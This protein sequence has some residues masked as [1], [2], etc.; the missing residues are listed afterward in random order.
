MSSFSRLTMSSPHTSPLLPRSVESFERKLEDAQKALNIDPR[1]YVPVLYL[2]ETSHFRELL[3][4]VPTV[5]LVGEHSIRYVLEFTLLQHVY[6]K[7]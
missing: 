7:L 4:V 1:D 6:S 2:D 5:I 3:A